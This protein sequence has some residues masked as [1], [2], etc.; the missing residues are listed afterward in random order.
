M[1]QDYQSRGNDSVTLS[2][3]SPSPKIKV[4]CCNGYIF[5]GHAF[6]TKEYGHDRKTYNN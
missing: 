4:K 1:Y 5:N 6:H 3:L 2:L